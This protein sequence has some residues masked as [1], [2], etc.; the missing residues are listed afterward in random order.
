MYGWKLKKNYK[1]DKIIVKIYLKIL[2]IKK[3]T[4]I[5]FSWII[6]NYYC[7][8]HIIYIY[9]IIIKIIIKIY[10]KLYNSNNHVKT[11]KYINLINIILK[12]GSRLGPR[13]DYFFEK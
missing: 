8:S 7:Y 12:C 9:I 13:L 3:M 2:K 1:C 10:I 11:E 6:Y 5:E 4:W